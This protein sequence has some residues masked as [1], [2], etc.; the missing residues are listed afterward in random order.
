MLTEKELY[1]KDMIKPIFRQVYM[2][3]LNKKPA[4]VVKFMIDF[5]KKNKNRLMTGEICYK[6]SERE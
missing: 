2:R 6:K 5:L 3:C 1:L 4:D